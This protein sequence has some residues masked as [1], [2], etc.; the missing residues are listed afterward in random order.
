MA[1]IDKPLML[2][3]SIPLETVE[4][5][6][7]AC[8]SAIGNDLFCIPDGEVGDRLWW[9][10]YQCYRVFLGH[11]DFECVHRPEPVNGVENWRPRNYDDQWR[12]RVKPGLK[13]V[14]F[15]DPGWR[16]GYAKEAVNS[17]F[18]FK[19]LRDQGVIPR[20]VRL[21]VCIPLTGSIVEHY[22]REPAD[23]PIV[24]P[25]YEQ[26]LRD[27]IA[28]M[29]EK[30]PPADLA[31]QWDACSEILD[32]EGYYDWTPKDDKFERLISPCERLTPAIPAE[33]M[34]GY[35]FCYG[36]LGGWPIV[37]IKSLDLCVRLANASVARS[38]R[39]VDFVHIPAPQDR[40][41]DAFYAPLKN[42]KLGDTKLY[43]G[44]IHHTDNLDGFKKRLAAARKFASDFGV[45][46]VCGYGRRPPAELAAAL[47]A[48]R[49][50]AEV[51]RAMG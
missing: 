7:R 32:L 11:P 18:I 31:I 17:Y 48:H 37:P 28:K 43:L 26:A 41:D 8:A 22:F 47:K 20:G 13:A 30:I 6:F 36:T 44:L 23:Y 14:H 27:E 10:N 19:T 34:V 21:Q 40:T 4:E 25:A 38:R 49:E 39:R 33:V 50:A 35:H 2:V 46:S 1:R 16:L 3:G 29:C 9:T 51:M 45:A 12:F 15:G 5:V 42:L 24:K